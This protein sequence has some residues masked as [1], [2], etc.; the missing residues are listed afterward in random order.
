MSRTTTALK[1]LGVTGLAVATIG[2][3]IPAFFATAA[4]ANHVTSV[5]LSPDTDTAATGDCNPFTVT[6]APPVNGQVVDVIISQPTA[7]GTAGVENT[8]IGFCAVPDPNNTVPNEQLPSDQ[9]GGNTVN[10]GGTAGHTNNDLANSCTSAD[11]A[12]GTTATITCQAEFT[13]DG[14]G[15]VTF[16][17][18]SDTPGT[19]TVTAFVEETGTADNTPTP[20]EQRDTSTKFW[21]QGGTAGVTSVD[22]EP[23]TATN[24]DGTIH[25]FTCTA[26]GAQNF[27][28]QNADIRFI[29]QS[30]PNAGAQGDCGTFAAG[31]T[32]VTPTTAGTND[33]G[34]STCRYQDAPGTL[35]TDTIVGYA[36]QNAD[37][38]FTTG[39]PNDVITKTWVAAAPATAVVSLTCQGNATTPPATAEQNCQNPTSDGTHGFLATVTNNGSPVS[40]VIVRFSVTDNTG[41]DT[42][43]TETVSPTECTTGANGTCSTTL[44]DTKPTNGESIRV[45]AT[46]ART[47]AA[48][49][50]DTATKTFRDP[51]AQEART[52]TLTPETTTTTAGTFTALTA[53]V[54]DRFGN[55]VPN[56]EVTFT[57]TGAGAFRNGSSSVTALTNASGQATVEVS[58]GANETPGDQTVTAVITGFKFPGLSGI[59]VDRNAGTADDECEQP[60][61]TSTFGDDPANQ[62]TTPTTGNAPGT[63]AGDCDDSSTVR[64]NA[65]PAPAPSATNTASTPPSTPPGCTTAQQ[66]LPVRFNAPQARVSRTGAFGPVVNA[67]ALVTVTVTGATPNGVVEL[68]AYQQNHFG[69]ANFGNAGNTRTATANASGVATF[70][71]RFS[72]NARARAKMQ[73][74]AFGA[75]AGFNQGSNGAA[76]NVLYVRTVLT[77]TV[78]RVGTRTIR[79]VG[80]SLPARPGG[81]IVNI[82]CT[83]ARCKSA[84]NPNGILF[85][86]RA[87]QVSGEFGPVTYTFAPVFQNN[88]VVLYAATGRQDTGEGDAQNV[89][90]RSNNRSVL[91][92]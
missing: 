45:T 68:Q 90:G 57:E 18:T 62:D 77:F 82:H 22:C 59:T 61:G 31:N 1:R 24:P 21:V 30:G 54:R 17:V 33:K 83:D 60:A 28:L 23:E 13:T 11:P 27:T 29:V 5:N 91:I 63:T 55:P 72:S 6:V 8:T 75:N 64:Y 85:Q 87:N 74:C 10:S 49:S 7:T 70:Q 39:E 48:A 65:A 86:P 46:L 35:G 37:N 40:G 73:G 76:S 89:A 88:R 47:G 78:T 42:N 56:V 36:D 50:T 34:V 25:E 4:S 51:V 41:A 52:I 14:N 12:A 44:T 43:D 32:T 80:D 26:R 38:A 71:V 19:M 81:L 67:T 79:I 16:G 15:V 84:S 66:N 20:G 9:G 3:G 53:T 69:T 2:A 58:A 92:Y